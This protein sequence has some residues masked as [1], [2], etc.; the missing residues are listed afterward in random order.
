VSVEVTNKN[1]I[2]PIGGYL[3]LDDNGCLINPTS[4]ENISGK[5]KALVEEVVNAYV[6]A[7]GENLHSVYL[8]GS[9][10]R[11]TMISGVSDVD[12][13]CVVES[14]CSDNAFTK[15]KEL[16]DELEKKHAFS[17][18]IE[19]VAWNID[20]V[21]STEADMFLVKTQSL[22]IWGEDLGLLIEPCPLSTSAMLHCM[23]LDKINGNYSEY[24]DMV[25]I[26]DDSVKMRFCSRWV[27]R[28][29]LRAAFE[30]VMLREK[31]YTRDLYFCWLSYSKYYPNDAPIIYE[32]LEY[33]VN[34]ISDLNLLATKWKEAI[35]LLQSHLENEHHLLV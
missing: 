21:L 34:P 7:L 5:W 1:A 16:V 11:G 23:K 19:S 30:V 8:R 28:V 35:V 26:R 4:I 9:V 15:L 29:I 10:A 3:Y 27:S 14:D 33:A 13:Y 18:G 6:S 32:F 25:K 2:T 31:K 12:S 20:K 17:T 24:A 22:C